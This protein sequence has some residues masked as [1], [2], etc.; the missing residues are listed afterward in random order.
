MCPHQPG[1]NTPE[2]HMKVTGFEK[3]VMPVSHLYSH[4]HVDDTNAGVDGHAFSWDEP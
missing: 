1:W 4:E 2:D 3:V